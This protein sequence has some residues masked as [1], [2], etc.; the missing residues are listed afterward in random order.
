VTCWAPGLPLHRSPINCS[1]QTLCHAQHSERLGSEMR[2][3]WRGTK[4]PEPLAHPRSPD[5][6]EAARSPGWGQ[7]QEVL[8][9][10]KAVL[11]KAALAA[12]P[13]TPASPAAFQSCARPRGRTSTDTR[14]PS[15]ANTPPSHDTSAL[16]KRLSPQVS[17]LH[18]HSVPCKLCQI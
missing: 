17:V 16:V 15:K 2:A 18:D 4:T 12:S 1:P 6:G 13:H 14:F 3:G 8:C 11:E 7:H 10:P 5:P 9:P